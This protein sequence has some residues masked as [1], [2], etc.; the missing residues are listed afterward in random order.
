[1]ISKRSKRGFSVARRVGNKTLGSV[2]AVLGFCLVCLPVQAQAQSALL[3]RIS[4]L[5]YENLSRSAAP[6]LSIG[7]VPSE[8]P[9]PMLELKHSVTK[10]AADD[11]QIVSDFE[12]SDDAIYQRLQTVVQFCSVATR[13]RKRH[14]NLAPNRN[15]NPEAGEVS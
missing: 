11:C 6:V 10:D 13:P 2:S 3:M 1:M 5:S 12:V 15:A 8:D 14:G 9:E 7:T 4:N